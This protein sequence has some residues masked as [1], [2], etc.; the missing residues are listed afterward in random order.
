MSGLL[1]RGF[2]WGSLKKKVFGQRRLSTEE[3]GKRRLTMGLMLGK[4]LDKPS[5]EAGWRGTWS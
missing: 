5:R 4:D 2:E 3:G 1:L